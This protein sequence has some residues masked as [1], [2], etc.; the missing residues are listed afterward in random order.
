MAKTSF[1][2]D[3]LAKNTVYK[4]RH[5]KKAQKTILKISREVMIKNFQIAHIQL[6]KLKPEDP[7]AHT[8]R[9]VQTLLDV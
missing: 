9:M 7:T 2:K 3:T 8:L 1:L 4:T 6:S 5:L